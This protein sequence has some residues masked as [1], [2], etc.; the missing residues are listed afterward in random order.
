MR[1]LDRYIIKAI[2]GSVVLVMTVLLTLLGLFL[3]INEQ[4][5]VGTGSY[6]NLQALR[7][8]LLNLP[9]TLLQF[10]PVAGLIGS[11]LA[12]GS[13]ARGSELTVMR[14]AG[15][16]IRR[17]GVSAL[18]AG[19]MLL[20]VAVLIGEFL[21]PP[22]TQMARLDKAV[23]RNANIS[24]TGRGSAWIRQGDQLVRADRL[25]GDAG[26]GGITV[27][28]LNASG[29]LEAVRQARTAQVLPD[30]R[31]ELRDLSESRFTATRVA[32]GRSAAQRLE[33]QASPGFLSLI[34]SDPMQLS[35]RELRGAIAHLR[36]NGQDVR[37]Y[38]FAFWSKLAGLV[39]LPLAVLLAVPFLFG[40]LRSAEAGARAMLGL[41]LG[42]GYFILQR[43]VESGTLAFG[44]DPLLLAWLPVTLLAV[45]VTALLARI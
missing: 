27:F 38:R 42:L 30:G 25:A 44:L 5:W 18:L 16:S 26:F 10:L 37:H 1:V 4:G 22:L 34:A 23:Q 13:L 35:Q 28:D 39:A 2:A 41:A 19:L 6:G 40:S 32:S 8:V 36:A 29:R 7:Y 12:M 14:A 24:V 11:L 43:M 9:A 20:P 21:A 17:I 15:I 45:V 3:F 33:L 31:W